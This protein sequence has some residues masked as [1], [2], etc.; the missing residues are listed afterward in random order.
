M[1][2]GRH[3]SSV[4]GTRCPGVQRTNA[5]WASCRSRC[6]VERG[7]LSGRG[8][9]NAVVRQFVCVLD[10]CV[11][12]PPTIR[13]ILQCLAERDLYRPVWQEAIEIEVLRNG[14]RLLVKRSGFDPGD[15]AVTIQPTVGFMHIAFPAARLDPSAWEPL[16]SKMTNNLKDRHVLAAA[17]GAQATHLVTSNLRDFAE[18][19]VPDDIEL[20]D[21]QSFCSESLR[22]MRTRRIRGGH[23][24]GRSPTDPASRARRKIRKRS[25]RSSIRRGDHLA[26]MSAARAPR[27]TQHLR[28]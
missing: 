18:T 3:P 5:R 2:D 17:V 11:L 7:G 1:S 6:H 9:L 19:S 28:P 13:D 4:Q 23:C 15:V 16:V 24:D 26:T 21:P 12:V 14:A 10:A 27:S 25:T 8:F 22:P 20:I